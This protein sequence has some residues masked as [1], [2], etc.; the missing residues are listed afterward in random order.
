MGQQEEALSAAKS[1]TVHRKPVS[2]PQRSAH[3]AT[4]HNRL[5]WW[6][7]LSRR[8]RLALFA[9][10]LASIA[11]IIGL[12]AGLSARKH[13]RNLPLPSGQGGPFTGDLTYYAPGLGACGVTSTNSDKIVAISHLVFDA[14]ST[15]SDPNANPLCGKKTRASRDNKSVDLSVVDRCTGCQAKDLDVTV[16]S[17]AM[18]ADA[19]LG[20]VSVEWN[21]LEDIPA[22]AQG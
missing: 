4:Q 6:K 1:A 2:T 12:A 11:L 15:G 14:A 10:L 16:D 3:P 20:R 13:S 21:W 8:T 9:A 17:F 22:S 18:L 5:V 7:H 19:N